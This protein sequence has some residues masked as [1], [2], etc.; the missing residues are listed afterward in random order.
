M[1][2][3]W[4]LNRALVIAGSICVLLAL[5]AFG[6]WTVGGVAKIAPEAA[7]AAPGFL[8]AILLA[9]YARPWVY[10]TAG[11]LN[12][13]LPLMVLLIFGGYTAL[14]EP[15]AGFET[16]SI[17]FLVLALVLSLV[18]G[19]AGFVQGRRGA[20]PHLRDA[21]RTR[22]GLWS[23]LF[24]VLVAGMFVASSLASAAVR[25]QAAA[26]GGYDL[27]ADEVVTLSTENFQFAPRTLDIPA[28]KLVEIAITNKDTGGHTFTYVLGGK[29]YDHPLPGG[30]TTK[31]LVRF[32]TPQSIPFWCKPHSNGE[33]DTAEDSMTGTMVVA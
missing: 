15:I 5:F 24:V 2:S 8:F 17:L 21:L 33:G 23:T 27:V 11:I 7:P 14:I 12:A 19:I 31:V 10:L 16:Q 1:Q 25:E 26:G 28:G 29:T 13:V 32:D 30:A 22:H 3:T 9:F 20:Q 18:G 4:N 6:G